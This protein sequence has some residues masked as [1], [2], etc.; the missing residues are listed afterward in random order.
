M[1]T[2]PRVLPPAAASHT[3]LTY[4]TLGS[5]SV[6]QHGLS[7][8]LR[9]I[10]KDLPRAFGVSPC[11]VMVRI[12]RTSAS[13][14]P[15]TAAPYAIPGTIPVDAIRT[16]LD[17]SVAR[18]LR[19]PTPLFFPAARRFFLLHSFPKVLLRLPAPKSTPEIRRRAF[20]YPSHAFPNLFR[21]LP[22]QS[23]A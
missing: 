15:K 19:K 23:C 18:S 6:L 20:V 22:A 2:P 7:C 10:S 9:T 14:I 12:S 21:D 1:S 4:C 16:A 13:L 17:F 8:S 5:T 3:D 11:A